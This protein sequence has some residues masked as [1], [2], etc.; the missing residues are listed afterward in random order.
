LI[1]VDTPVW[2]DHLHRPDRELERLLRVKLV[3]VHPFVVGELVLG[4]SPHLPDLLRY[5][6]GLRRA[7][8]ARDEEVLRLIKD[9]QLPGTGIGYL[10][11]HLLASVLL[12]SETQLWT[13]DRSLRK[14]AQQLSLAA[15]L[16]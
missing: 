1:L 3:L 9:W 6:A 16:P 13:R 8:M 7:R 12:T 4:S 11:A 15:D 14:V 10:D 2:I 5:L